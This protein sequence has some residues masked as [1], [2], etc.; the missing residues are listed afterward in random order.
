M[1][2]CDDIK[3]Y[4][5]PIVLP[6][7]ASYE[8]PESVLLREVVYIFQGIEGKYIRFENGRDGFKIDS[9]VSLMQCSYWHS[10]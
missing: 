9:K 8:L 7:S 1:L 5:L 4:F 2:F 10:I 3:P 6:F